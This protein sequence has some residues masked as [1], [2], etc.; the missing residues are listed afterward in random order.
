MPRRSSTNCVLSLDARVRFERHETFHRR[1]NTYVAALGIASHHYLVGGRKVK[2]NKPTE[3]V[4]DI[5]AHGRDLGDSANVDCP[6]RD[7]GASLA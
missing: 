7:A 4:A 2:K 1:T 6:N 3:I 5:T